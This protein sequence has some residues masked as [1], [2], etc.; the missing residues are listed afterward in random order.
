MESCYI[1]RVIRLGVAFNPRLKR[2]IPWIMSVSFASAAEETSFAGVGVFHVLVCAVKD[3]RSVFARP[4][5]A[6]A[7]WIYR[8]S[9][10]QL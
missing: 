4:K 2:A 5:L 3:V 1:S 8:F 7:L 10:T 9:F 6:L